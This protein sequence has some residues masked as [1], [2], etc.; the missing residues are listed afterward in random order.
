MLKISDNKRFLVYDDGRPFFWLAD[1]A[2]ELFHRLNRA[3]AELYLRDRAK[4]KFTVIQAVVLAEFDGLHE[5]NA[6]GDTPL[7]DDDPTKPNEKYFEHV[8]Y[9]VSLAGALGLHIGML[10]TWG[11]KW[12]QRWGVGPLIFNPENAHAYGKWLATRY[13][14]AP[15]V[16]ILGGDRSVESQTQRAVIENMAMGLREGDGGAH[17]IAFHPIGSQSS[18]QDFHHAEWL[19]FNMWQSGHTR[20]RDN[21]LC[22]SSDYSRIPVKPCLDAE[23]G[24]EDHPS[25]FDIANGFLDDYD[26]RRGTY[27]ALF[28]GAF[29]HTYGCH[30]IW[31]FWAHGRTPITFCRRTW[32]EA[33]Q[34]PG[35]HQMQHARALIESRPFLTRIPDQALIVSDQG[36]GPY[37]IRA[38]RDQSGSYAFIYFPTLR[39]ATINL[40]I[41]SGST[42]V[43][44]WYDPRTGNAHR[45]GEIERSGAKEFTPPAP[46]PDWVLV[47]DDASMGFG[48]PGR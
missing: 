32:H 14:D 6:N 18:A 25:A 39:S 17:L 8:D 41:L 3:D 45:I 40:E 30:P 35:A 1:T 11:D 26:V 23:N 16:W 36:K 20:N 19:D 33:M 13:K 31:Q 44:H 2:W 4:K 43:V 42:L 24:Y 28:A 37:H 9:I 15:I 29:G 12:N 34:L 21:W 38:T 48:A 46:W 47:L 10:P 27:W 7:F 22:I 5:P